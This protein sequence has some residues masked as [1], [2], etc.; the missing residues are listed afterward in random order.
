VLACGGDGGV[1][2]VQLERSGAL[3]IID[4]TPVGPLIHNAGI[5]P[6]THAVFAPYATP[7]GS[8]DFIATFKP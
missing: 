5:D 2:R 3:R 6:T 1:T 8:G 7:D 4:T